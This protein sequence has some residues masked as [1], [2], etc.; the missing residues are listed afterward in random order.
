MYVL[1]LS[2]REGAFSQERERQ[3]GGE[4]EEQYDDTYIFVRGHIY[5]T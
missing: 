4:A 2:S 1:L 5:S 3:L